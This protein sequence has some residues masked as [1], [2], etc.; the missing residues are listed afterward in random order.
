M[1]EQGILYRLGVK[2]MINIRPP[3]HT[4]DT[5]SSFGID[6][7]IGLF[8]LLLCGVVLSLITLAAEVIIHKYF[9]AT[10]S[11]GPVVK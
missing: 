3:C 2:Y 6:Q 11:K 7:V 9:H 4:E 8:F 5:N 1:T 10:I